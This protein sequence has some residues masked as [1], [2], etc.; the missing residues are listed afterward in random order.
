[1][2]HRVPLDFVLFNQNDQ[3]DC[4]YGGHE[5]DSWQSVSDH[6]SAILAMG[7]GSPKPRHLAPHPARLRMS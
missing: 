3:L 6:D 5:N 7:A 4:L 2:G 1:M